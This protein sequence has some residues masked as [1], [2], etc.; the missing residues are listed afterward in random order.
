M[1]KKELDCT[2][3][4]DNGGGVHVDFAGYKHTY[5]DGKKAAHDYQV[6]VNDGN[7][8]GWDGHDEDL[9][10][11]YGK[12]PNGGYKSLSHEEIERMLLSKNHIN[13]WG[14]NEKEFICELQR[15]DMR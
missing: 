15:L 14:E 1:C 5:D 2:V 8:D 3:M 7:T 12:C 11:E 9:E 13:F 10:V 6:F 4:F